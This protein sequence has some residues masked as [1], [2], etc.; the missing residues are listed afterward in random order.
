MTLAVF[1]SESVEWYT[2][3]AYLDAARAVLGAIDLD[4][5]SNAK[6]NEVVRAARYFTKEDD[7]LAQEWHGR[8]W[9]NPPYARGITEKW[10]S[11]LLAEHR[12]GRVT[13]AILLVNATTERGWFKPLWDHALCFTDHRIKFYVPE[14]TAEDVPRSPVSGNVFV[15]LGSKFDLF[16]ASFSPFGAVVAR[17]WTGAA[18]RAAA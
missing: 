5:A 9:L 10:I 18:E 3:A 6:A 1:S 8:I 7:G 12:A 16:S 2:P 13:E 11:K 15:Y 4:P 17:L 14:G